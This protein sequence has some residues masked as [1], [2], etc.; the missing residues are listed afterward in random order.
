MQ[1]VHPPAE[2]VTATATDLSCW[3]APIWSSAYSVTLSLAP[4]LLFGAALAGLLHVLLPHS[5]AARQLRGSGGVF[6][7]VLF[8][9]PLPLCSC[10]VLPTGLGLKKDGASDGA[11]IGFLISTPQ[12][13]VDSVLVSAAFLGWPFAIFKLASAAITGVVGGLLADRVST[14]SRAVPAMPPADHGAAAG[15]T[16]FRAALDHGLELLRSIWVWL[17]IGIVISMAIDVFIPNEVFARAAAWGGLG[18]AFAALVISLPLY[19]CATASVPIAAALVAGG[20][21]AGAALVFLMAGPAT[22]AATVGAIRKAFGGRVLGIYLATLIF[23]SIGFGLGFDFLLGEVTAGH[24]A[25][26]EHGA[27]WWQVAS[28]G[29]LALLLAFFALDDARRWLRGRQQGSAESMSVTVEGMTCNGCVR[30][31]ETRLENDGDVEEAVVQLEP[32]R[33]VVRGRL[34]EARLRELIAEAGFRAG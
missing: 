5:F 8:G 15:S 26:H 19:V 14:G 6:K 18:A 28:A 3:F 27:A 2:A 11:S 25:A 1:H 33:A 30:S 31:L 22:N 12:T 17:V 9:V 23:G 7:A 32:P 24:M 34:S 4:S 21:P 13:G 10:G 16:K 20:L 29:V